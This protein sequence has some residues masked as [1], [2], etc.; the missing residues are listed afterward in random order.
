MH[1]SSACA[2]STVGIIQ[3]SQ[4]IEQGKIQTAVVIGCDAVSE[5]VMSGFS[6]LLALGKEKA[7]PFDEN[8][9]GLTIGESAAYVCL[10][11]EEYAMRNN[12]TI[13]GYIPGGGISNDSNH[14]TGPSRDG[15]GLARAINSAIRNSNID[16]DNI[17]SISAHGTATRF[18][19][20]MEMKAFKAVFKTPVPTYSVKGCI[21]HTMGAAGILEVITALKSFAEQT[22][23]PTVGTTE[24]DPEALGWVSTS[25]VKQ[26]VNSCLSVNSGFGGINAAVIIQSK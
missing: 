17:D 14:I 11:S 26:Q 21:G 3:A 16:I 23:P 1:I 24:V 12:L 4:L 13:L 18:N 6:A 25:P 5:F 20:S 8:R 10:V 19:D 22:L 2:S 15:S 7:K 9:D